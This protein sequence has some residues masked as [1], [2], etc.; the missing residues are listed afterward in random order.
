MVIKEILALIATSKHA[1]HR[2]IAN[3]MG[4]SIE[5]L[6]DILKL[7]LRKGYLDSADCAPS[8]R[9]SC[10]HCPSSGNCGT[11]E[12]TGLV[13]YITPKGRKYAGVAN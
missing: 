11:P 6:E 10:V 2:D 8:E 13:Y 7:L 3:E 5:T 9:S 1:L 4:I 12:E